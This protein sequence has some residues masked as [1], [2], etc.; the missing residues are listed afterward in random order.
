MNKLIDNILTEWSYLVHDG[1]PNLNNPLHIVQLKESMEELN[2]PKD[3][4]FEFIQNLL[5]EEVKFYARNPKGKKI[6]VFTNKDNYEDAIESGYEHV[7]KEEAEKELAQ[8]GG[9]KPSEKPSEKPPEK[10]KIMTMDP[11]LEDMS[12]DELREKDHTTTNIQLNFTVKEAKAQAKQKGEKGVG[13][14]TP[15]S[16]AGEAAVHYAVR[17]L[18]TGGKSIDDVKKVLMGLAK[19]KEKILDDKWAKAAVNTAEWIHDVYG[20]DIK[21]VVWDTPAGRALIGAEGHGTSSD[22]FIQLKDGRNIGISLKQ[23]TTVFLLNGGY[24]KQHK[25][26]VSSLSE[27]LEPEELD[28]FERA[29]SVD[30]YWSGNPDDGQDNGFY[31]DL[32]TIKNEFEGNQDFKDAVLQRINDYKNLS[33]EEFENIFDSEGYRKFIDETEKII[34]EKIMYGWYACRRY[35]FW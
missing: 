5:R 9:E 2:L 11:K 29:T 20:D 35:T 26:L 7:D 24:D 18:T 12:G 33:E 34:S 15:E 22:M 21:E 3:F 23:T 17:E 1:M 30:T 16:R 31:G 28:A 14:G 32:K 25:L 27:T 10:K 19:D 4:I 13:L 6:S 8:Q